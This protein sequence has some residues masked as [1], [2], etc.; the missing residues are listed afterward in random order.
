MH[1]AG[2]EN[3]KQI[4]VQRDIWIKGG[5]SC[6]KRETKSGLVKQKKGNWTLSPQP[7]EEALRLKSNVTRSKKNRGGGGEV[8]LCRVKEPRK[9][10]RT[11]DGLGLISKEWGLD[12]SQ[13]G[14]GI[15]E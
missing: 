7:G 6:V 5:L 10:G 3:Q 9:R 12:L 4:T 1:V 15:D 14:T 13:R 11:A 2:N 8:T